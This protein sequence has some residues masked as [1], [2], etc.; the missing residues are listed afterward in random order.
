MKTR[1]LPEQLDRLPVLTQVVTSPATVQG[2]GQRER[3]FGLVD[4]SELEARVF[5][6]VSRQVEVMLEARLRDVLAPAFARLS[7]GLIRELR[8]PLAI[9]LRQIVAE[10]VARERS[11]D[12]AVPPDA[13]RH[14]FPE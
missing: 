3:G 5:Q 9:E 10:A 1:P 4:A 12:G 11:L 6:R 14:P 7:D 8:E 2:S 13:G